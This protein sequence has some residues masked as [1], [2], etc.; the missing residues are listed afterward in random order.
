MRNEGAARMIWKRRL[1]YMGSVGMVWMEEHGDEVCLK[2]VRSEELGVRSG[3]S[4]ISDCRIVSVLY[5]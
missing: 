5:R 4:P 3:V 2:I 1:F